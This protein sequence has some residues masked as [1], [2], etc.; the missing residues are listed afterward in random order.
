MSEEPDGADAESLDPP[1]ARVRALLGDM[2]AVPVPEAQDLPDEVVNTV[3]WQRPVRQALV[4]L[5]LVGGSIVD[6][7]SSFWRA[8]RKP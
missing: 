3:R 2:R 6:G 7:V 5:N 4:S 8:G 1:E